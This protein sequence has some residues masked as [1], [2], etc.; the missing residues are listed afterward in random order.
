[1]T[2]LYEIVVCNF[3]VTFTEALFSQFSVCRQFVLSDCYITDRIRVV[4][5][6]EQDMGLI[7][8]VNDLHVYTIKCCNRA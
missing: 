7:C 1:M 8:I 3:S 6:V 5:G 2:W 4:E